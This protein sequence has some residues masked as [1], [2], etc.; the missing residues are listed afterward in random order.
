M[1][2]KIKLPEEIRSQFAKAGRRGGRNGSKL[3]KIRAAL[4]SAEARAKSA[5]RLTLNGET[6]TVAEWSE[7]RGIP[8]PTIWARMR[9]GKPAHQ[10]LSTHTGKPKK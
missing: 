3:D 4:A 8:K 1:R 7:A 2:P 9:A 6:H 10:V 5:L